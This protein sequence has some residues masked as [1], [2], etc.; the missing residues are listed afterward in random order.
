MK[1]LGD[2]K[3]VFITELGN[4]SNSLTR[5]STTLEQIDDTISSLRVGHSLNSIIIDHNIGLP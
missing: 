1:L 3:Y 5:V 2:P 4:N